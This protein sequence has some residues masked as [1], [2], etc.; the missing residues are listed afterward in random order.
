MT[1]SRETSEPRPEPETEPAEAAA[2][3]GSGIDQARAFARALA[4]EG[5][6]RGLIGPAEPG[7]LWTRHI[8]NSALLAPL[9]HGVAADIG[10]GAGLPGLVCAIVRPDV[11]WTLIEPIQRRAE[12]LTEQAADLG[13][14]NV[15]VVRCRAE[16]WREGP[17]FDVVTARAVSA[18]RTL[19]PLAVPLARPG[20][21]LILLKGEG[22]D[23]EI[24]AAQRQITAARLSEARSETLGVGVTREP[25][26]VFRAGVPV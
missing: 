1:V 25:T 22:V 17:V 16:E 14:R 4:A 12:W 24:E 6:R 9:T 18:L 7:R 20:G 13:L 2:L 8:L 26:R 11:A 23:R 15:R 3:F 21:E 10:S 5:E 19:I